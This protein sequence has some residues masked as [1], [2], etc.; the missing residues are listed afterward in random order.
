MGE[1][2]DIHQ[3]SPLFEASAKRV[4]PKSVLPI[5]LNVIRFFCSR[6]GMDITQNDQATVKLIF[7]LPRYQQSL[8]LTRAR[9]FSFQPPEK[10]NS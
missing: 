9:R 10:G 6:R 8:M 1:I 2:K 7:N 4:P 3:E 5:L